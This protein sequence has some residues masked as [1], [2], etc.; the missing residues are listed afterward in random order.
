MN[1]AGAQITIFGQTPYLKVNTEINWLA[2][3]INEFLR[4]HQMLQFT[5][6]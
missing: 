3:A 6:K 2:N 4:I 1:R 5:L